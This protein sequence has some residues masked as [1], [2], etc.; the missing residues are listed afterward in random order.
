MTLAG[1][2]LIARQKACAT[3]CAHPVLEEGLCNSVFMK[4]KGWS[5]YSVLINKNTQRKL[6][7]KY[8]SITELEE[9]ENFFVT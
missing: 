7:N 5:E 4:E 9:N 8:L 1:S 2:R 3:V 6:S